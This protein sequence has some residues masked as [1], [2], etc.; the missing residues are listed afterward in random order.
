MFGR[1][2]NKSIFSDN[3]FQ[4]YSFEW[5]EGLLNIFLLC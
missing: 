3:A 1:D 2:I 4:S 5:K